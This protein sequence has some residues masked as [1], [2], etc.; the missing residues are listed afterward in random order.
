MGGESR[1]ANARLGYITAPVGQGKLVWIKAGSDAY[2]VRLGAELLAAL[3][4]RRRD[5]RLVLTYEQEYPDILQTAL[6]GVDKMGFGFGPC[7]QTRVVKRVLSRLQPLG[8]IHIE[9]SPG[10]NLAAALAENN[11]KS[12]VFPPQI[13]QDCAVDDVPVDMRTLWVET[14]LEPTLGGLIRQ[15]S[16][17]AL[18]WWHGREKTSVRALL[19]LWRD[20]DIGASSYLFVSGKNYEDITEGTDIFSAAVPVYRLSL[21]ER[22]PLPPGAAIVV[23]DARWRAAVAVAAD[24]IHLQAGDPLDVWQCLASG[25]PCSRSGTFVLPKSAETG[26]KLQEFENAVDVIE[27]WQNLA[28][29]PFEARQQGDRLRRQFW[30]ARRSA[31]AALEVLL[32][33]VYDW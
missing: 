7:D 27:S 13:E 10:Q 23:D 3:R 5:I 1:R 16:Q 8:V 25:T 31:A 29:Q 15:D 17:A 18:F 28:T 19:Q 2:S 30:S 20:S 26:I 22:Q 4:E 33:Q 21:W 11:T 6:R 32:Q 14:Q 9:R 12:V 24:G